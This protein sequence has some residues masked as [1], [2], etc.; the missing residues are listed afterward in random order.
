MH[1]TIRLMS[2]TLCQ[3]RDVMLLVQKQSIACFSAWALHCVS[4][5]YT[6]PRLIYHTINN[7]RQ[8]LGLSSTLGINPSGIHSV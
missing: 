7:I 4:K 5:S 2:Q 1:G 3:G 8:P 6:G